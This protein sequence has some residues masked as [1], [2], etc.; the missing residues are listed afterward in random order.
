MNLHK[1]LLHDYYNIES[2]Y[3][4]LDKIV[5]K[6]MSSNRKLL[7]KLL[8]LL[9]TVYIHVSLLPIKTG[10]EKKKFID[11]KLPELSRDVTAHYKTSRMLTALDIYFG[12][13]S[14]KLNI[15]TGECID[16]YFYYSTRIGRAKVSMLKNCHPKSQWKNIIQIDMYTLLPISAFCYTNL[17]GQCA[18][19]YTNLSNPRNI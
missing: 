11:P 9:C 15:I 16:C 6:K 19:I 17:K 12:V 10:S 5:V 14:R 4:P 3:L 2:E 18:K 13:I 7:L 8:Y 1:H